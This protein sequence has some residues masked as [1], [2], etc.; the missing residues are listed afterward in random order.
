MKLLYNNKEIP[1]TFTH[2]PIIMR[3]K[4]MKLYFAYYIIECNRYSS[5][6]NRYRVD[7]IMVDEN[8]II[9]GYKQD[10]HTNTVYSNELAKNCIITPV[11]YFDNIEIGKEIYLKD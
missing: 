6:K 8:N 11:G 4:V 1:V 5:I 9:V 10:M 7:I 2:N 3:N